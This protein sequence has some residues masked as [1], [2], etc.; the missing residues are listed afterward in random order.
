MALRRKNLMVDDARLKALATRF[1][2][3]ESAA[4]RRAVVLA[5][6]ADEAAAVLKRLQARGTLRDVYRRASKR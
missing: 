5:L 2:L 1:R 4:V 6:A 3:S